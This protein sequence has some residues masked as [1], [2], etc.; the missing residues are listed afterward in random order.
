VAQIVKR[1]TADGS[2]R[3]DVRT[4]IAGR[5]VCKT[6]KRKKDAV[7]YA[8]TVEADKLRAVAVDP[9]RGQVS[10]S[11]YS[12]EWLEGRTDIRPTTRAKYAHL[13]ERHILPALGSRDVGGLSPSS[14]R[15]WYMTLR[16][17]HEVTA[18]DAYR[19]LRA[20]LNTC[21][22]D[23]I[24]TRNPCQIK[25]A[26]QVR[27]PERRV[28]DDSEVRA[29]V[30]AVPQRY[31]LAL[32]LAAWCALRRG[33]VLGLQRADIDVARAELH[34]RRSWT[35]PMGLAPVLGPPKSKKG[36]RLVTIPSN[37]VPAL[38]YH[39]E[40]FVGFESDSWLFATHNGTAL[41]PRNLDRVWS[42]AREV[43]NCPHLRLHDYA[44]VRV[45]PMFP[46]TSS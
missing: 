41:S 12:T 1:T 19:L 31:R 4:R 15:S 26:G 37:V 40:T 13:L 35:A 16:G 33:E 9:R 2:N 30:E 22:D 25:G 14:V 42:K 43:A 18:D 10:L 45:M 28:A 11:K 38:Q 8:N 6:F 32:L 24:L 27:S 44:D 34:V 23:E 36:L 21:A 3:Y 17:Q 39:L 20:I 46:R 5:V 29:A 7:S